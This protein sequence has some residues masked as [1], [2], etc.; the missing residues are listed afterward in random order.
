MKFPACKRRSPKPPEVTGLAW[1]AA[2][3]FRVFFFSGALWSMI[4]VSLWPMFYAGGLG[5]FPAY[6]HARIM[7][8]AF[9]GAF[10]VGFLGTAGPRMAS[11]PKLSPWEL[12]WLFVVHQANALCHLRLLHAWGD[13]LFALLLM[14]LL[15]S[16]GLRV[17]RYREAPPPPQM[18]LALVGL[19]C[20][21]VG[22]LLMIMPVTLTDPWRFRFASLLLNQGL[23]LPPVLGIGSFLFPRMLG[24]SFGEPKT[25]LQKQAALIG[26]GLT[27]LLLV[28][29]FA[30]EVWVDARAGCGLRV[31]ASVIYLLQEIRW[32]RAEGAAPRGTL[33]TGLRVALI[34]GESGLLLPGFWPLQR[35]SLEHLL[36]IGGFGLLIL[37]V[38][39]R[40]LFGHSGDLAGFDRRGGMARWL[41]G[42]ALLAA[43]TRAVTGFLPQL[44]V[45][46]H[47]YAALTWAAVALMWLVWHRQRFVGRDED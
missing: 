27:S 6:S 17:V 46:H 28:A 32:S 44:T 3:P 7:I 36:Y 29:S 10:V 39:S 31:T 9:G 24:G 16:L 33:A 4:G 12:A 2:E 45:S 34:C 47:I 5:Y 25:T 41:I 13:A 40:V 37:V 38:A 35:V 23:L 8:E 30:L 21:A 11:A 19:L 20:G 1:L 14:S 42:L 15:A 26:A 18:L 22:A 43:T